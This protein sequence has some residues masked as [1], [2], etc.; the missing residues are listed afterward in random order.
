MKKFKTKSNIKIYKIVIV[1][2]ILLIVFI[3]LSMIRLDKSNPKIINYLLKDIDY[4]NKS[5]NPLTSNIDNLINTY[6]FKEKKNVINKDNHNSTEYK[7]LEIY[8]IT[9]DKNE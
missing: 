6:Y 5:I 2:V 7:S 8:N 4:N 1:F 9:G 3:L